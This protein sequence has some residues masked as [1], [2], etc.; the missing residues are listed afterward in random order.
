MDFVELAGIL[1][2]VYITPTS[3]GLISTKRILFKDRTQPG[4]V[5]A[6]NLI[7]CPPSF[8]GFVGGTCASCTDPTSRGYRTSVAWQIQ[9]PIHGVQQKNGIS[10][11]FET[12]S[13]ITSRNNIT[14][15]D[16]LR[17]ICIFSAAKN[18]SC[19][20]MDAVSMDTPQQFNMAADTQDAIAAGVKVS[21]TAT[22][23]LIHCLIAAAEN[24]TETTLFRKNAAEYT[25]RVISQGSSIVAAS[26]RAGIFSNANYLLPDDQ[27]IALRCKASM[28]YGLGAFLKCAAVASGGGNIIINSSST[29]QVRRRRSL[30]FDSNTQA[31][32][33][34]GGGG[35]SVML[36]EHQGVA[37]ASLTTISWNK[38]I[39]S[40]NGN[41]NIDN[42]KNKI[43]NTSTTTPE[44]SNNQFPLWIGIG[45]GILSFL[46]LLGLFFIL[47]NRSLAKKS[48]STSTTAASWRRGERMLREGRQRGGDYYYYYKL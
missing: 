2:I 36:M 45:I 10:S 20:S 1:D 18:K 35:G 14:E 34:N 8:F 22:I 29:T 6:T 19:P 23:N 42:N 31:L 44:N 21:T 5:R 7:Y 12:F 13:M 9:C 26:A 4:Y 15:T 32:D 38:N 24:Q 25:T 28:V 43:D 30:L 3:V 39:Y 40:L 37:V 46:L 47:Y 33:S 41:N 48:K 16:F 27:D 11:T 17:G